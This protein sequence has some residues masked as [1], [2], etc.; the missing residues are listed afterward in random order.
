M[1]RVDAGSSRQ[2]SQAIDHLPEQT[3][4]AGELEDGSGGRDGVGKT[5]KPAI[6]GGFRLSSEG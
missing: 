1:R 2:S 5:Q 4:G 6:G 3:V